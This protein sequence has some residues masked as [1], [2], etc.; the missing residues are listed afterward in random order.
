MQPLLAV[1][2]TVCSRSQTVV[3]KKQKNNTNKKAGNLTLNSTRLYFFAPCCT[4]RP[5]CTTSSLF[6]L[7]RLSSELLPR[8]HAQSMPGRAESGMKVGQSYRCSLPAARLAYFHC[9][10]HNRAKQAECSLREKS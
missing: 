8:G 10:S 3:K 1:E 5:V 4:T 6:V 9:P 2:S 7:V